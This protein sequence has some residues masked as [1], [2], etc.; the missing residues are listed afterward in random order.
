M[1][2]EINLKKFTNEFNTRYYLS[3]TTKTFPF[4]EILL[5]DHDF[6]DTPRKRIQN[7]IKYL[8]TKYTIF[9]KQTNE[10]LS[11]FIEIINMY[12]NVVIKKKV[13]KKKIIKEQEY[14]EIDY[15]Q[16]IELIKTDYNLFKLNNF[17]DTTINTFKTHLPFSTIELE[18]KFGKPFEKNDN[19]YE[20][21]FEYNNVI[22]CIY[23]WKAFNQSYYQKD[24]FLS[25]NE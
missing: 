13:I 12:E 20:Y 9:S 1:N 7:I 6:I 22:Y 24:W 5:N 18:Y 19:S 4:A 16:L 17:L 2:F 11:N 8:F 10:A 25:T 14:K 21:K 3:T 23:D 15:N